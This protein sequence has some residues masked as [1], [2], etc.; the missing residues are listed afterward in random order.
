MVGSKRYS[1][2]KNVIRVVAHIGLRK[3]VN[4]SPL[5]DDLR[6]LVAF[7]AGYFLE[8]AIPTVKRLNNNPLR[9]RLETKLAVRKGGPIE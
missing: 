4:G 3:Y 6:N 5:P 1:S 9:G 8:G 7:Y 2:N